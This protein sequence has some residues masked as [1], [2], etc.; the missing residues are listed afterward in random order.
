MNIYDLSSFM[1]CNVG[2]S[3]VVKVCNVFR[4]LLEINVSVTITSAV[5][6][7]SQDVLKMYHKMC[8]LQCSL[9]PLAK[10]QIM[11]MILFC[12]V[13]YFLFVFLYF[14]CM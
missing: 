10:I 9:E 11:Y 8:Y 2:V 14:M 5:T 13:D 4:I 3:L 7:V 6:N 12:P 1:L